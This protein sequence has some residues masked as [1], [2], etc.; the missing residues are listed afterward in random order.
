MRDASICGLGQTAAN[1]VQSAVAALGIFAGA[2]PPVAT[3][4]SDDV[5]TP[6]EEQ[7]S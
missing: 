3:S 5:R 6:T 1:A 2:E 7:E 4:A